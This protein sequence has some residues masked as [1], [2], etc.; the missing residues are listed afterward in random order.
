MSVLFVFVTGLGCYL[1]TAVCDSVSICS[2]VVNNENF[3]GVPTN[4]D[5]A[6]RVSAAAKCRSISML[7]HAESQLMHMHADSQQRSSGSVSRRE[8]VVGLLCQQ[9]ETESRWLHRFVFPGGA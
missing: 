4:E 6:F 2:L 7:M 5:A 3:K 1:E 8:A 9:R